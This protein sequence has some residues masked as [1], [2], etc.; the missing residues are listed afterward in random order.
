MWQ[1]YTVVRICIPFMAGMAMADCAMPHLPVGQTAIFVGLCLLA[2]VLVCLYSFV[3]ESRY[4]PWF[5][6]VT[7]IFFL[8]LGA[9]LYIGR[10]G[11]V[12]Y[13]ATSRPLQVSGV[14][15]GWPQ[16]K[17]KTYAVRLRDEQNASVLLYVAKDDGY[18]PARLQPGDSVWAD[19]R[20][21]ES[22][23]SLERQEADAGDAVLAGYRR[24]LFFEGISATAYVAAGH[25]TWRAERQRR[26]HWSRVQRQILKEY[27]R[28]G[29]DGVAG[30]V[31]EAMTLG[32]KTAVTR[33]QRQAFADA[34][35]AH[36]LALSGFHLTIL[37]SLLD[38]LLLRSRLPHRW[39]HGLAVL[40]IPLLWAF[41]AVT[42]FSPSLLRAV[43][44]CTVLQLTVLVGRRYNMVNALALAAMLMLVW[45]PLLL[46][47]VGFQLSFAS[48][49][50][51]I[52]A[53]IPLCD[54]LSV[55]SWFG[56]LV[57][58]SCI[59]TLA[60]SAF[61]FPLSAF[62]F[63]RVP[64]LSVASNL[65][66]SVLSF[67]LLWTAVGWWFLLAWPAAQA[68]MS[69]VLLWISDALVLVAR[70][71]A[72]VPFATFSCHP[73]ALEVAGLYLMLIFGVRACLHR[74]PLDIECCLGSLVMV[75]LLALFRTS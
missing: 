6:G 73:S 64:L 67:G 59:I 58:T 13:G 37:L 52:M 15:S 3:S 43:V 22:T 33:E 19:V 29:V 36:L 30:G 48:M 69:N 38:L 23:S 72:A 16:E 10:F 44:M 75:C 66:A 28:H 39:R 55:K 9:W 42:G 57:L 31:V 56:R 35:M 50:G 17:A 41:A 74:R 27:A 60:A 8:F 24:H 51:I 71:A 65:V 34:G 18:S 40:V 11:Q 32:N 61:T 21:W 14:V 70:W 25:W 2:A 49:T 62:Y 7:C 53:G 54:R 46:R 12:V 26:F 20:H 5:G 45:N 47:Q 1:K 68:W 63:G 4:H